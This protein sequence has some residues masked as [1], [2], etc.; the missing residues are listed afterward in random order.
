MFRQ[1]VRAET[2]KIWNLINTFFV[3]FLCLKTII[4]T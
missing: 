3:E 1:L 2:L 4:H